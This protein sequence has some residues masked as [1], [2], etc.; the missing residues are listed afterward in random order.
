MT[1]PVDPASILPM[2]ASPPLP[3]EPIVNVAVA[4]PSP[5]S[6]TDLTLSPS[7]SVTASEAPA[8]VI[9]ELNPVA[10]ARMLATFEALTVR[11][12]GAVTSAV[13]PPLDLR[14]SPVADRITSRCAVTVLS[15]KRLPAVAASVTSASAPGPC[16]RIAPVMD[17]L[18]AVNEIEPSEVEAPSTVRSEADVKTM[19]P[20]SVRLIATT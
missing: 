14:T 18:G 10:F 19:S 16:G 15:M 9:V 13:A 1:V 2:V 4:P 6:V 17:R 8:A 11:S 20:A 12:R 5:L 3:A 7:V